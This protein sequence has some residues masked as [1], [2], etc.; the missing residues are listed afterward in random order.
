MLEHFVSSPRDLTALA[1]LCGPKKQAFFDKESLYRISVVMLSVSACERE[2]GSF[3]DVRTRFEEL[4]YSM[5]YSGAGEEFL[6]SSLAAIEDFQKLL[7]PSAPTASWARAWFASI[8]V[9]VTNVVTLTT[10]AM[11]WLNL[12]YYATKGLREIRD[13]L[14]SRA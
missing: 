2:D 8:G 4:V 5:A 7:A 11:S 14:S 9:E 13:N 1:E 6:Q 3:V 10:F 12:F